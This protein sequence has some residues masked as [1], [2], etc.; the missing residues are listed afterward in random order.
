MHHYFVTSARVVL[1]FTLMNTSH[2]WTKTLKNTPYE[3]W[4]FSQRILFVCI[5]VRIWNVSF[6][7]MNL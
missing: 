2:Q 5:Q 7:T 6:K 4:H 1:L 3:G